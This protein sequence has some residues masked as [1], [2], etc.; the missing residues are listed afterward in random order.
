MLVVV[1]NLMSCHLV[2]QRPWTPSGSALLATDKHASFDAD[3]AAGAVE[4]IGDESLFAD[5]VAT[6]TVTYSAALSP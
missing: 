6:F 3:L 4:L 2:E 1:V 5:F